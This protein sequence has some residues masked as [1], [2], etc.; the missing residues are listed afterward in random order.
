M[1]ED[2]IQIARDSLVLGTLPRAEADELLRAG[3][4]L[5]T[6]TCRGDETQPWQ[7]LAQISPAATS[8]TGPLAKV[9]GVATSVRTG[10]SQ[11]AARLIF[12]TNR[13]STA[14]GSATSRLL[15][16]YLPR[17]RESVSATLASSAGAI[18]AKLQDETFQRKLF[19]AA[20]DTLPRPVQ[21]FVNEAAFVEFCFKH[22]SKLLGKK[23]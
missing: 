16:D 19:G 15:E 1:T 2:R 17:I 23:D 10:V 21:R 3:F 18:D 7:P 4:L 6:D 13:G 22:R 8:S 9:K 11:A 20:Y 12:A 14:I 5:P